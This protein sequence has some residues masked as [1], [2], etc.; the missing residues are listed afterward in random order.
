M[1]SILEHINIAHMDPPPTADM[2]VMASAVNNEL[3][4]TGL[5]FCVAGEGIKSCKQRGKKRETNTEGNHEGPSAR[6]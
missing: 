6:G 4:S 2:H 1:E 3:S 5:V